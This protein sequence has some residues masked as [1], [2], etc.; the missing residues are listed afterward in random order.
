MKKIQG[1][2]WDKI[3]KKWHVYVYTKGEKVFLGCFSYHYKAVIA[4]WKA[5]SKYGLIKC[6][7]DS[8]AFNYLV[9]NDY[10]PSETEVYP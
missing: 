6:D 5:E 1:V 7:S 3:S 8:P 4:K 9:E 10:L 2:Q